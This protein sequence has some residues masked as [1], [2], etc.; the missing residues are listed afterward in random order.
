MMREDAHV[1]VLLDSGPTRRHEFEAAMTV[2]GRGWTYSNLPEPDADW[3][4][5]SAVVKAQMGGFDVVI[6]PAWEQ[7]G[8]EHHNAVATIVNRI[9]HPRVI[10]YL[11]YRRGHGRSIGT[12]VEAD[13]ILADLKLQALQCYQSQW[14]D[15][16]T[17][18]WFPGGEYGT[19][20]EWTWP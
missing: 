18:P 9:N 19:Y 5:I 2:A 20:M 13:P 17:A 7:D 15:P 1:H 14:D 12:P 8:H 11:T 3:T 10:R 6:S 16:A 4:A